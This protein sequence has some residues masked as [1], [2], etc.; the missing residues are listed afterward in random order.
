M[1]VVAKK[2]QE[3][4]AELIARHGFHGAYGND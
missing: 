4:L 1:A 3:G 2:V